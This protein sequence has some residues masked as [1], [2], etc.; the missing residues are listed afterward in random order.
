MA[1]R[2]RTRLYA[3]REM[4]DYRRGRGGAEC[5]RQEH[6]VRVPLAVQSPDCQIGKDLVGRPERL[7]PAA[8][9]VGGRLPTVR[10]GE[11]VPA[12]RDRAEN[13]GQTVERISVLGYQDMGGYVD[14]Q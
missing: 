5:T 8:D 9:L 3:G 13:P 14:A 7:Y 10:A 11:R 12:P 2:S 1:G 6:V 4:A